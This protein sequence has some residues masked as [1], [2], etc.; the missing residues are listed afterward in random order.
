M[1]AAVG[2]ARIECVQE[3]TS[4]DKLVLKNDRLFLV[5][6]THGD[7]A[8]P[9]RCSLG[10]FRDDTRM[11]SDYALRLAGGPATLL[12]AEVP[13]TYGAQIDLAVSDLPFGGDP[14]DPKH[15][16]HVRRE[17]VLADR[18]LE[19]VTLTSYLPGPLDYW[20]ELSLGAD[21]ADIFEVRGWRRERRGT[22]Y[23]PRVLD[24]RLVFRYRGRDGRL[25]ES[26][27]LF[28]QPPDELTAHLAR[29][30]VTLVAQAPR[31][32]EW[33]VLPG[34]PDTWPA[35]EVAVAAPAGPPRLD[36]IETERNALEMRYQEWR[37]E[38]SRWST[39]SPKLDVVLRRAT[40]DLRALYLKVD[41]GEVISAGIPWYSTVFG[42]D[43]IITAL[44]TL[45]L[46]PRIARDTLRYLARRQGAREDPFTEEQPGK[47]LH[48]LRRGEMARAGEIP[49][50][51]YF[52]TIDATPLWLVLLHETWRWTG[53]AALVRE[54]MPNAERALEW[55]DR[56]G[57]IDGDGFVEYA[58]TSAKGLV[59]QGWKD[60]SD[61]V[62]FP[63]GAMPVPPVALVEVQG[64]V[65]DAK[66]RAADLFAAFGEPA[67][68]EAL[69]HEAALLREAIRTRFWLE[70]GGTF[71]LA[72]DGEKQP[73]PTVASN[74]GHLLWSRV[75]TPAQAA[76]VADVMLGPELFSGW[77]IRTLSAAHPVFNP[78][79]YHDGS[80]WPHDNAI[81]V[82]GMALYG[83]ARQALPVVRGLHEAA[84]R[85]EFQRL[86]EL[87]CGMTRQRGVRPVRYPV[88][89]SPQGWA[90]GAFF[91]LLQ[92]LLGVFPEAPAGLLHIRNPVLPDFLDRLTIT[93]LAVGQAR[94]ALQFR[95]YGERTLANLLE[96]RGGPLQV[97]IEL[98]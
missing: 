53:D 70:H 19:R 48:E 94:V 24:D 77:G 84:V 75:P 74:A 91:M 42:R 43:S 82:L 96:V 88:S 23:A 21:F 87:F 56:W 49:H 50:I 92:A 45:P 5:V 76:R 30:R 32:L 13:R 79:S 46:N 34:A 63:D 54:L 59:N 35:P 69:R 78:M 61:G 85:A 81:V 66:V 95:R 9:G 68:A 8:P 83:R 17:L 26:G 97:R 11:L 38:C 18:L 65:Y 64:Y 57:D 12:S 27:V 47:I 15:A 40:D 37:R 58:R 52:G 20:I 72:L 10:F 98:D 62:P 29:W 39:D 80:V 22:F 93:N 33:E 67:R 6:T 90:S 41:G 60:S 36:L 2:Y 31:Q 4:E 51:P 44:E 89:C 55:I 3:N 25:L 28:H 1:Q 71:A 14:W 7:I 73:V 16:V 86:P